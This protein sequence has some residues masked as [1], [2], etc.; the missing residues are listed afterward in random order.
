MPLILKKE[1]D[2]GFIALW[3]R[4]ESTEQL[5][6][7]II[8]SAEEQSYYQTITAED[9]K[10]E[11]LIWHI[12]IRE[13]IGND[14][15]TAYDPAGAPVLSN[16][17][18]FISISHSRDYVVLYYASKRC[19]TDIEDC[20]RQYVRVASRIVS[21]K[22]RKLVEGDPDNRF[23][24]LMWCTKEAVYKFA[25]IAGIDFL[26]DIE[27]T[28][29]DIPRSTIYVNLCGQTDLTLRYQ[30]IKGQCLVYTV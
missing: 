11:W 20:A 12:M 29:I 5:L 13:L 14:A 26:K 4:D 10:K 16:H 21:E 28:G 6:H 7:R 15:Y 3:E 22:E 18:G 19:G 24:A 8:L 23:W 30:F 27:V 2:N 17:P 1:V 9:R 25:G